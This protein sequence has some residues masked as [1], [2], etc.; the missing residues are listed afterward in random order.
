MVDAALDNI[1]INGDLTVGTDSNHTI[2]NSTHLFDVVY[3][4]NIRSR[5]FMHQDQET[6]MSMP[7]NNQID[8]KVFNNHFATLETI[9]DM[10]WTVN[11]SGLDIDFIIE[12]DTN[13]EAF[14]IDA[15]AEL[16]NITIPVEVHDNITTTDH[17]R[18]CNAGKT[19]CWKTYVDAG[20]NLITEKE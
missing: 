3:S 9:G 11:P 14:K 13:S 12:T 1:V 4:D 5:K 20:G 10:E 17:N 2:G 8:F 19:V 15:G 18:V 7:Y 6:G 16:L